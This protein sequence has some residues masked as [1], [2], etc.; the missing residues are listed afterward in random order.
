MSG[1]VNKKEFPIPDMPHFV[2]ENRQQILAELVGMVARWLE[3]GMPV[4]G[5]CHISDAGSPRIVTWPLA[6]N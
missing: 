2:R 1:N 6:E 5:S 4:N 3:K